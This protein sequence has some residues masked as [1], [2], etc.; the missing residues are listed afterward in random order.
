[1]NISKQHIREILQ[2]F[3]SQKHKA[4]VSSPGTAG[5]NSYFEPQECIAFWA[6]SEMFLEAGVQ[7]L[8]CPYS[9]GFDPQSAVVT[10]RRH[11]D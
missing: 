10:Q 3:A 9:H 11:L 5:L 1:M 4:I 7:V 6:S 2:V 8:V